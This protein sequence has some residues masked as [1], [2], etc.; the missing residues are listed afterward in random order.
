M[1]LELF[2]NRLQNLIAEGILEKEIESGLLLRI[3]ISKDGVRF[4]GLRSEEFCPRTVPTD[5]LNS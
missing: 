4:D 5:M 2:L 1:G 3:E